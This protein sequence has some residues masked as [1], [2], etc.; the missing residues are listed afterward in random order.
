MEYRSKLARHDGLQQL[1]T[2]KE[3]PSRFKDSLSQ[4]NTLPGCHDPS[5]REAAAAALQHLAIDRECPHSTALAVKAR[6]QKGAKR[7]RPESIY[8]LPAIATLEQEY[9]DY[10]LATELE[11]AVQESIAPR[12]LDGITNVNSRM[13]EE[14]GKVLPDPRLADSFLEPRSG[15]KKPSLNTVDV[16]LDFLCQ[17]KGKP[18]SSRDG[19]PRKKARAGSD[20]RGREKALMVNRSIKEKRLNGR[21][22]P[23]MWDGIL[24]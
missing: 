8:N 2:H 15:H 3:L 13:N 24:N 18:A 22:G 12:C 21:C 16:D 20:R 6:P 1:Q 14:D 7:P 4:Y 23:G 10:I 17:A 9:G 5:T 19:L 11:A